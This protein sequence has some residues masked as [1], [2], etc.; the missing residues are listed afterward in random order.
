MSI[1]DER[2]E[3]LTCPNSV[4]RECNP[5]EPSPPCPQMDAI[6]LLENK[7]QRV[8]SSLRPRR[9]DD[10]SLL[11]SDKDIGEIEIFLKLGAQRI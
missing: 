5:F 6:L 11:L 3:R 1:S 4:P 7:I 9:T 10:S 8:E 2:Y